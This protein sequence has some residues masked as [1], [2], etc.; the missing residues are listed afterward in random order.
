MEDRIKN[1]ERSVRFLK[2]VLVISMAFSLLTSLIMIDV[3][4]DVMSLMESMDKFHESFINLVKAVHN[5][6]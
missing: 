6:S 1:L 2:V 5:R 4:K 3:M